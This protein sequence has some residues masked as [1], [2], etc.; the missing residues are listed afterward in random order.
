MVVKYTPTGTCSR[1]MEVE[2]GGD[3]IIRTVRVNG[4]CGGN[5]T[6]IAA[7]LPGMDARRAIELFRGIRCGSKAT[8]C[9]DQLS[10]AL[11]RA[12]GDGAE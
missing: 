8:S 6:G 4:G 1:S 10:Y 5:N 2:V 12:L 9:P 3:G 7:L 11:E